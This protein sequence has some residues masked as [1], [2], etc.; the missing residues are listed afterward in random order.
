MAN[1][2]VTNACFGGLVARSPEVAASKGRGTH[3]HPGCFAKRVWKSLIWQPLTFLEGAKSFQ[4]Y[5]SKGFSMTGRAEQGL[6]VELTR[7]MLAHEYNAC[8]GISGAGR[9]GKGREGR[10]IP[11]CASRRFTGAEGEEK[12]GLLLRNDAHGTLREV[13]AIRGGSGLRSIFAGWPAGPARCL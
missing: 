6:S 9:N 2:G 12:V 8:Q 1:K 3:P 7:A 10:E 4:E 13:V 5:S 11:L